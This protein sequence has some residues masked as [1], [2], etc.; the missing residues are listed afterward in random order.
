MKYFIIFFLFFFCFYVSAFS[1]DS[2]AILENDKLAL[3]YKLNLMLQAKKSISLSYY[4]INEDEVGLK[5]AAAACLKAKQGVHVQIIIEKSRSKVTNNLVQLFKKYGVNI[6]YYNSFRFSKTY[7]NFSW[8]HD[9]LLVVD[10]IYA[11]LGG[12]NLNDKYYPSKET[13]TELVDIETVI[14]GKAAGDAQKYVD[15]LITSRFAN[16]VHVK[17]IDT[18]HYNFLKKTIDSNIV[19]FKNSLLNNYDSIFFPVNVAKFFNDNYKKW[20]KSKRIANT[21]LKNLQQAKTNIIAVSPYLIPPIPFMKALK[22]ASRRGVQITLISN[23]PQVSDAQIIAAAYMN[24]RRKYL[25]HGIKVYEYNGEKM[26]HDKLFLIDDSITIVGSYNFDNISYRMNSENIARIIDPD[27]GKI[28]KQH[29]STRIK[30]CFEVKRVKDKNPY[31][32]KKVARKTK[33][34]RLLLRLFPFIRRFL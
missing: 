15:H 13:N 20:P 14:K 8:L 3:N 6:K 4:A 33:C 18:A 28:I 5:F 27:F 23:S 21:I 16:R 22:K 30:D 29:I 9:K 26:L 31:N 17:K 2:V 1:Q 12:R 32:S 24:D 10:S 19:L 34:N 11:V 25:K 7:K